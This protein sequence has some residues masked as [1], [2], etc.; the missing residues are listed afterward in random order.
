MKAPFFLVIFFFQIGCK[1]PIREIEN[2][3]NLNSPISTKY[4]A[5]TIFYDFGKSFF[6]KFIIYAKVK[7]YDSIYI[8]IGDLL[9][10]NGR[11]VRSIPSHIPSKIKIYLYPNIIH[12]DVFENIKINLDRPYEQNY[13]GYNKNIFP[14]RYIEIEKSNKSNN[15]KIFNVFQK[16][17]YNTFHDSLGNFIS[18]DTNLNRIWKLCKHT[19]K[20]TNFKNTYVDGDRERRP[21]EGDTYIN[22]LSYLQLDTSYN[23]TKNTLE[24]LINNPTWPTEYNLLIPELF[25]T[26]TLYTGDKSLIRNYYNLLAKK[27]L[28]DLQNKDGVISTLKKSPSISLQYQLGYRNYKN[29]IK[30]ILNYKQPIFYNLRDMVDWPQKNVY[31]DKKINQYISISGENDSYNYVQYNTVINAYHYNSLIKMAKICKI[32]KKNNDALYFYKKANL[33]KMS[34][35]KYFFDSTLNLYVDGFGSKHISLHSNIFPLNFG[36]VNENIKKYIIPFIKNK[37]MSCSPYV[38]QFLLDALFDNN[39]GNYAMKLISNQSNRSWKYML[40]Q[41]ANMTFESWNFSIN[42]EMDLSHSWSTAPLNIICRKIW[43]IEPTEVGYSSFIFKPSFGEIKFSKITIPTK[44]GIIE[45][46]YNTLGSKKIVTLQFPEQM[47]GK[48]I[49]SNNSKTFNLDLISNRKYILN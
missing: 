30:Q 29:F 15:I 14:F 25:Y 21:Y 24:Y 11:I 7:S 20:A 18:S 46:T 49:F 10:K 34:F 26:Y 47:K 1:N 42:P 41:N 16:A 44:K 38:A 23:V 48:I 19:I 8:Y 12:Y 36:L 3:T 45:G 28:I 33:T 4:I 17:Y 22:M 31:F 40:D 27:T 43:G 5:D 6:S 35:N 37:G 2:T 13:K 39:E 32:L 9:N